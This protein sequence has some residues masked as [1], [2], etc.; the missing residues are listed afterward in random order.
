MWTGLFTSIATQDSALEF[1][2]DVA[3]VGVIVVVAVGGGCA[4]VVVAD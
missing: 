1:V 3:F 2:F 4:V